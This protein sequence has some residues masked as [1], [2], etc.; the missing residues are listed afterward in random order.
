MAPLKSA[1]PFVLAGL[2]VAVVAL[3]LPSSEEQR[4]EPTRFD[5]G[6]GEDPSARAYWEWLRQRD[7]ATGRI[8]AGIRQSELQ[9]AKSLPT[10]EYLAAF[11]KNEPV[12]LEWLSRGP[13][14]I[15]GRTRALGIDR[16]NPQ[17][18]N[19]GGVSGGMW[20]SEDDGRTWTKST[21]PDQHHSV[22]TLI[23]DPRP[24]RSNVWYYGSGEL[25]GN[26][27]RA[28][29]APY[30][31]TGLYRS[32]DNGKTWSQVGFTRAGES[33]TFNV[34]FD[35]FYNL[36]MDP[37]NTEQTEMYVATFGLI[38]KTTDAG[39]TRE[40][41][42]LDDAENPRFSTFT[43]VAVTDDG[44][45]YAA[46]S[47]DGGMGGIWRSTDGDDFVD[48]TPEGFPPVFNRIVIGIAPSNQNIVYFIGETPGAGATGHSLWR[49]TYV[50]GDGT[51]Q[52]GEWENL[53]A[54]IPAAGDFEVA[55]NFPDDLE[56]FDSQGGYD[57][58]IAVKPDNPD[59]VFIGGTNLYR[60]SDGFRSKENTFW[61]GGYHPTR[62][63]Y[64]DQ[65]PDQHAIVFYPD[66]PS[67]MLTGDDGGVH[68][69]ENNMARLSVR[70][71]V[72]WDDLN[73]GYRT[74]QFY[75]VAIDES[76][77]G[78]AVIVGGM[79]DN[80]TAFTNEET[81]TLPWIGDILGGDGAFADISNGKEFYYVST[82]NARIFRM[83]LTAEGQI[84]S[85]ARVD[86]P[87]AEFGAGLFVTPFHLDPN[88]QAM[89]YLGGGDNIWRNSN[90]LAIP[91]N[92]QD[93]T[94]TNWT[95]LT[96]TG[97][98]GA[99][100][101]A[102]KP[103][104]TSPSSTRLYYATSA[105]EAGSSVSRMF[106]L[107]NADEG[108]PTP[109][110]ITQRAETG[111]DPMPA[112]AYISSIAVNPGNP[113][114]VMITFSNYEVRS[115]FHTID[116]GE[117]WSDVS[118]NLEEN[119]DGS[120]DGPSVRWAEIL[121]VDGGTVYFVGT[122][123][124]LYSTTSLFA[125]QIEW[126]QE[127][128]STIG[129]VVVDML[130]SRT[131]DN[132]VVAATHGNG[133]YS[134]TANIDL[135]TNGGEQP[136]PFELSAAYPN[137]FTRQ[138]RFTLKLAHAQHVSISVFDEL[139]RRVMTLHDGQLSKDVSHRFVFEA[140]HLA[141]GAYFIRA[142]GESSVVTTSVVLVK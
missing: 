3:Q 11:G 22:T 81:G 31:G 100:V 15:G 133:I 140:S 4:P 1:L 83:E 26:S 98:A 24:G 28:P 129:N 39:A 8:P 126:V 17:V 79:Q 16:T 90:L 130:D 123:T 74:T 95:E 40:T 53:T 13:L 110:D 91:Q 106:R 96:N 132:L 48:I 138:T 116:G 76:A 102:L 59:L 51:G 86:P 125:E 84:E 25:I 97:A 50:S 66:N 69:T 9:F 60:S 38:Y 103:V 141:G 107:E 87:E 88:N 56:A 27:A 127:G 61:I 131:T 111:L 92:N 94:L 113:D 85:F 70:T 117:T 67:R 109:T 93:E 34:T 20:H 71:P 62:F 44:V 68:R 142:R 41:R 18:I 80:G 43:D 30:L 105:T 101:T 114:E 36:A 14:E 55:S 23:Q 12:P 64:P 57:L 134:A 104:A 52:G 128:A 122:S 37:S 63:I 5:A 124:G 35:V 89:M 136:S 108:N 49:F 21:R 121:P 2:F 75:S 19:A 119:P 73:S 72:D 82:Q 65:H 33:P 58:V 42:L 78:D 45:V 47:S 10:R 112:G 135:G 46:L 77:S 54:N 120:G 139:G 99:V 115:I 32:D 137:P 6:T 118:G 7:P 29:G